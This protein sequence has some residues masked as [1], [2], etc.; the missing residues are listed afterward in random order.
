MAAFWANEYLDFHVK[1]RIVWIDPFDRSSPSQSSQCIDGGGWTRL[2]I[3]FLSYEASRTNSRALKAARS[4][5]CGKPDALVWPAIVT[6]ACS[7]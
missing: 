6:I 1:G 3:S 2:R 7:Y 4:R 5:F